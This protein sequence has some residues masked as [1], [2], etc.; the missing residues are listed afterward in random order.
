MNERGT[1][2]YR[3]DNGLT[4]LIERMPDVQSAAFT[5]LV[6]SGSVYDPPNN[7]GAAAVLCEL[8]IRGA[9]ARDSRQL[10]FELDNLGLQR[11]ESVATAHIS[12]SGATLAGN[13]AESLRIYA[14]IVMQPHLPADQ[15]DAAR[16][17]IEQTL[18]GL[19]DE[20]RQKVLLELRRRCYG[21]P[22]GLPSEG[23]LDEL[24]NL[25]HETVKLLFERC[26]CPNASILGIA[27]NIDPV[28]VRAII[29][30]VFDNWEQRPDPEFETG[31]GGPPVDHID[32]ASTQ[33][34]IGVAWP[35][36]PYRDPDY[37]AGWAAV[38]ALSGGMSSRLFTEVRE[39][40]GLCYA[41]HASVNS[42]RDDARVLCYAGTTVERAQ[43]TLDVTMDEIKRLRDGISHD[44]LE[45]CQARAKSSLVMQ[46][47]STSARASSLAQDWYHLDRVTSLDEI[48]QLIDNLTVR[49][50]SRYLAEHPPSAFTV[51]TIGPEPLNVSVPCGS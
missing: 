49:S 14:D 27:G 12:F 4:V 3:L 24:P 25:T 2:P 44:E 8:A 10:S 48:Q 51:L 18:T 16:A 41:V 19:E 35:T 32:Y 7:N 39:K 21:R 17:G 5:L 13:L 31:P 29:A 9:G 11:S 20:P 50:V 47:E 40:R 6:P 34:Q 26:F 37:Y 22:W 36:V 1:E 46:Q 42:L 15:F 23:S 43:E 30:D 28:Q 45:R 38:S 33:T